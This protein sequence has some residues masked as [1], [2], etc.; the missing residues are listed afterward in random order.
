MAK[1]HQFQ[2]EARPLNLIHS[3]QVTI[4]MRFKKKNL[5]EVKGYY[6]G[7][8]WQKSPPLWMPLYEVSCLEQFLNLSHEYG[9]Q[10]NEKLSLVQ[11]FHNPLYL[12]Y[13]NTD[14]HVKLTEYFY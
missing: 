2:I 3:I 8:L 12:K 9:T 13:L 11:S 7:F 14:I 6:H 10:Y 4:Y 1:L 5:T